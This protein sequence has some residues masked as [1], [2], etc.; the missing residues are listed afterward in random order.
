MLIEQGCRAKEGC[1]ILYP[2]GYPLSEP[3]LNNAP[4]YSQHCCIYYEKSCSNLFSYPELF[5][6]RILYT[7]LV[8]AE[9]NKILN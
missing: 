5:I 9:I 4:G 7:S 1:Y 2:C 6:S 3:H 8:W